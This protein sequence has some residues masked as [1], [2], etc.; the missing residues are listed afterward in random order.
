MQDLA[1]LFEI[2]LKP[3]QNETFLTLDEVGGDCVCV[4]GCVLWFGL[5]SRG[6]S[7]EAIQDVAFIECLLPRADEL[8]F[9]VSPS[10]P[11]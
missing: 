7:W 6:M 9:A 3:L 11:L 1:C 10:L 8:D 4:M 2:Y 5:T